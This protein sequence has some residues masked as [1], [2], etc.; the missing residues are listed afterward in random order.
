MVF[1]IAKITGWLL[2]YR[3]AVLLPIA[4]FEGPVITI[5]AGFLC[6]QGQFSVLVVYGIVILGDL[7]GDVVWYYIGYHYGHRFVKRFGGRFGL[8]EEKITKVQEKFHK[9]KNPI[10]FFS[11]ITNGFG[12]ALAV[13][14]TAGLSKIPFWRYITINFIGQFVWSGMLLAAGYFFGN[15]YNTFSSIQERIF[16]FVGVGII[17]FIIIKY[18]RRATKTVIQP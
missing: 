7:I 15:A 16:L 18:V 2:M 13:L 6:S 12:F 5:I 4:I 9:Y 8:T 11:K 14:F 10:L 17:L 3:Y 1:S